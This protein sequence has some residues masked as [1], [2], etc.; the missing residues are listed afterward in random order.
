MFT[1]WQLFSTADR[2][3]I[4]TELLSSYYIYKEKAED[5]LSK[6]CVMWKCLKYALQ[7]LS[8]ER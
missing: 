7:H 1:W 8:L 4:H 3:K 6:E 2:D 5:S